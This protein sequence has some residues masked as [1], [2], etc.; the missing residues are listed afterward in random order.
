MVDTAQPRCC[1]A[2]LS[3]AVLCCHTLLPAAHLLSKCQD[4]DPRAS[5]WCDAASPARLPYSSVLCAVPAYV[6][7]SCLANLL[8]AASVHA[9][10]LSC[11]V[12]W[13]LEYCRRLA[14]AV[15]CAHVFLWCWAWRSRAQLYHGQAL[16]PWLHCSWGVG[17]CVIVMSHALATNF[18]AVWACG[19]PISP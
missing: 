18:V 7:R 6:W 17:L 12:V 19:K 1:S 14:W 15:G 3:C 16:C 10:R 13:V 9:A 5:C 8:T 2:V 11:S 4:R